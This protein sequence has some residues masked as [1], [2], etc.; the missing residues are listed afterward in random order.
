MDNRS[1]QANVLRRTAIAAALLA[2]YG[3]G[4][5][6][7]AADITIETTYDLGSSTLNNSTVTVNDGG[8]ATGNGTQI[9]GSATDLV[10]VNSGGQLTL[11]DA[12]L[13]N[14]LDTPAGR[15]GRV[16]HATGTGATATL[17]ST[18]VTIT[19]HSTDQG[20]D[21]NHAFTAGV[22]A[23]NGG[24]VEVNGGSIT[25]SGSKRTVGMQANDGGSIRATG[26]SITTNNHFGHAVQAYRTPADD[27]RETRVDL[28]QATITTNGDNYA[29]G[30]QSANKGAV[31]TAT[32]TDITTRGTASFGVESFNG[33]QVEL[34]RGSIT[35]SGAGAAGVRVYGGTL[36]A[37]NATVVGTH[38]TTTGDQAA[39]VVAGDAAEPTRGTASLT[40]AVISTAGGHS[41]GIES[42]YGSEV[43]SSASSLHT[44]GD[45]AHGVHAHDGGSVSLD[46]DTVTTDGQNAYGLYAHGEDSR[47]EAT[48]TAI[49]TNGLHGYGARAE[50]GGVIELTGGTVT[51]SNPKGRGTQDG[52]GSRGYALTADGAGSGITAHGTVISTEGQRAYGA[53]ATDG[54]HITLD[55]GSV[56][57]NGFMA[58]GVYAS[59]EG[60]QLD[61]TDVAIVTTGSVGDGAWAYQGGVV[62][63]TGGSITVNGEPNAKTPYETAN[64]LVAVGGDGSFNGGIINAT[65]VTIVTTG[66]NSA[67]AMAGGEVGT[68]LTNGTI[69]LHDSSITVTGQHAVAASVSYGSTL[70]AT[71]SSL[72]STQGDGIVLQDTAT[73]T[74]TGTRVEAAGASLVSNLDHAGQTQNITVGTGSSLLVNNGTLLQVNRGEDGMDGIVNLT[75]GAGSVSRGDIVDLDGLST[76][77]PT[78]D[79]GGTTN[80]ILES[81][82][83]WVGVVRG[84]N[85]AVT[86]DGGSFT[87]NGGEPIAGNVSSGND[88][89]LVFNNGASIGGDVATGSGSSATFHNETSIGGS[90]RSQGSD[91]RFE[92][93]TTIGD[94][95]VA[96]A[97]SSMV[98]AGPATINKDVSASG[99]SLS[100]SQTGP[101]AIAGDVDL[102]DG[103]TL[104]GGTP[105]TPIQVNGG[106]VVTSGATLGGNLVVTGALSGSGGS[107]APGNS[108]GTQTYGSIADFS[109]AYVAEVNAAGQ[110]DRIIVNGDADLSGIDLRVAQEN[111]NGGYRLNHAYTI[112]STD[113]G[114]VQ[115]T[116]ASAGLDTSLAGTLVRLDPVDYGTDQVQVSL[117]LDPAKVAAARAGLTGN[118]RATLAGAI[119]V[120][121]L[122]PAA[123]A[124]FL[125][126]DTAGALDQLSGESHASVRA[127]RLASRDLLSAAIGGR[128]RANLPNAVPNAA[129]GAQPVYPV[130][131][132]FVGGRQSLGGG[133][134]T[135]VDNSA[136]GFV[137]GGDGAVGAGWRVGG[138]VGMLNSSID[139]A[140]RTSRAGVDSYSAA[141]YGGNQWQA[142]AGS[143]NLLLGGAYTHDRIDMQ[144][145]VA[146]G[147]GQTLRSAYGGHAVNLFGDVGYA[148][149]LGQASQLEPYVGVSW[150]RQRTDGFQEHGG[151]AALRGDGSDDDVRAYTLGLRGATRFDVNDAT[152][153]L[154]GGLG[155]RH[156]A[157][158]LAPR[159]QLAFVQGDGAAYTVQGAP[160][161]RNAA[162][163]SLGA[164]VTLG[165]NAA[166][167]LAYNGQF[168]TDDRSS[169][170]SLYLR[171][172]Y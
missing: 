1:R 150:T 116:F 138:A 160:I 152:V 158:D 55:G 21:Y 35:T 4:P 15:N 90:V 106:A 56:H 143:V 74:L 26:V 31:A 94:S 142:G 134:T 105:S 73:V 133:D 14:D 33:A 69:N 129:G 46:G 64:G 89:T 41:S 139:T 81:G 45:S 113:G 27:E 96:N 67:G 154:R 50:N 19:A 86:G 53:Y 37:G 119:S 17:N 137:L 145:Q 169:A 97:G 124:A 140:G 114:E 166:L 78:R 62:N 130:W 170:G 111:G 109:G 84:I 117:S 9:S 163:V 25:A 36:G 65:G 131:G 48:G 61:A 79:G 60:S 24:H 5:A 115:N 171:V 72:V 18:A 161:A 168:G 108:V 44:E 147:G 93:A 54:G 172:H 165:G 91:F 146:L 58:Y 167:G 102:S 99:S 123:D 92:G 118:Q 157:G 47:I 77:N 83:Q 7:R 30:I 156:A 59:G 144:R 127:A 153:T 52:D 141:L 135:Q 98:F 107:V 2:V 13:A 20:V 122:N 125:S 85:D 159:Q 16:V 80:F 10:L 104:H 87:D 43:A 151:S 70:S 162:L 12:Q 155:W 3:Y 126:G 128:M 28:D 39:G 95:L 23:S 32:D 49:T 149:P 82:A 8:V 22:G 88:A 100:F 51:T 164:E 103:A 6:V 66:S 148:V 42:A 110:S 63:L 57:T 112:L 136:S 120:A 121:G 38:I 101:T 40:G 29:V 68:A 11:D 76:S 71:D 75:L 132:Q 34:T